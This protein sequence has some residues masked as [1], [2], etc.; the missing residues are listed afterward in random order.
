MTIRIYPSRLPGEPLETHCHDA[1]TLHEWM[2]ANVSGYSINREQPVAVE[3]NGRRLFPEKWN[4]DILR[5]SDDVRIYPVPHGAVALAWVAVAMAVA[6][7]AYAIFSARG[8]DS[9]YQSVGSGSSLDLNPAKANSPALGDPIR[10]VFGKHQIYPDYVVSPV[11]RFDSNDPEKYVV[12]LF[13]CLGVGNFSF[14]E[15]DLRVGSTPVTSLGDGFSYSVFPPGSNV[16]GD[17]RTENWFISTE[18][19][20]TSSGSGLDMGTTAPE[21]DDILADSITV[22]GGSLTF[23]NLVTDDDGGSTSN[24]NKLP[25][26]WIVGASVTLIVP[27]SF[28][29]TTS[30]LYS[31]ISGASLSE[32]APYVGMPVSLVYNSITYSLL[33]A[34]YTPASEETQASVTLA[35]EGSNG[36]AFS[37]IPEGMQRISL[38]HSGSN[39]RLLSTDGASVTVARLIN[40]VQDGTWPGFSARTALDFQAKGIN[41]NEKW[42]G[43]F[44]ACPENETTNC[45]EVNFSFPSGICGFK[46]NG[47]K[48]NRTVKLELQYRVY[49]S[50]EGW[51]SRKFSYTDKSINGLGYTERFTTSKSGLVEVRC[52]RINEQG[53]KNCRDSAYWQALRARLPARPASYKGVT[54]MAVSVETGGKLAAQSDRRINAVVTR[55]YDRGTARTVSGALFHVLDSLS[56]AADETTIN[57]L[58]QTYWTPRHEYFDFSVDSDST[59]ALDILQ[60][61]TNAGMSYFLLSDGLASAG[62]EGVKTWTGAITP[63]ET[64]E[65][66]KTTFTLPSQDDYDGVDVTYINGD[67]WSEETIQCRLPDK[68]T[69]LKIENYKLDGV[70]D[71]DRAYRIGMRRLMGYR[72]EKL[73]HNVSTEMDGLCYEYMDRVVLADDIPGHDTIS[74]L[75]IAATSDGKTLSLTLSE[76]PAWNFTNP[77]CLIRLQDGTA[78]GLIKPTF[79]DEFSLSVPLTAALAFD[80]WIM[81]DPAVEPPRLI[82][83]SSQRVGYDALLKEITPSSDG[84]CEITATQY[85]PLKYQYDDASY[86]GDVS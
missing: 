37:G 77:V 76:P 36:A 39:Y 83:C 61:I 63:Q 73:T 35:Y 12:S 70:L 53:E 23:S 74:C 13:V 82:F 62:R 15:G 29:V 84:T 21:T 86:P 69:P 31:Q 34:S 55:Q 19:G 17:E 1:M 49:G 72:Y 26:S 57:S 22:A 9:S 33:I 65:E 14:S 64:T 38:S 60:A 52:R 6:S 45:F 51:T 18:V 66:L 54:T 58:E 47:K 42:L 43:P 7:A 5:P 85:T 20:G 46:D 24:D 32:L 80:E 81:D 68:P 27:D 50:G 28:S 25:E 11:G 30:G 78:T 2:T 40:G 79:I 44:L 59:S 71:K 41:D 48:K 3:I 75:I 56:M 8:M 4:I 16:G 10:E 67:T